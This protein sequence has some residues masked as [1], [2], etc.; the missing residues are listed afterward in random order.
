V[1]TRGIAQGDR[2]SE[3]VPDRFIRRLASNLSVASKE[4]VEQVLTGLPE[5]ER[6]KLLKLIIFFKKKK[7]K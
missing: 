2:M 6:A 7:K 4:S 5:E 1:A 3:E